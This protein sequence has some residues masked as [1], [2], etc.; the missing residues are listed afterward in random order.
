MVNVSATI[1]VVTCDIASEDGNSNQI[2][3]DFNDML[4][5]KIN[6]TNY[7]KT[8]PY[9]VNCSGIEGSTDPALKI[10]FIGSGAD[11]NQDLLKTS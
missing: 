8:I 4:I 7:T 11:F 5:R 3:I 1:R 2:S 10:S 9:K 6:E